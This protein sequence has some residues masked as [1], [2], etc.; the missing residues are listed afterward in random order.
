MFAARLKQLRRERKISQVELA[1]LLN[2]TQQ[3]VGKWETGRSSPDQKTLKLLADFFNTTTDYLLDY[4]IKLPAVQQYISAIEHPIPVIGSVKAGYGALAL[5]D[6][7]GVEYARVKNPEN[8]FYLTVKGNS[9]EPRIQ[10]GD[11]ALV[12][13]QN[14]LNDGDL[15]VVI[16]GDDAEGTLKKFI[17]KDNAV[18][19]QP[20]NPNYESIVLVGEELDHLYIAGKVI[21]TKTKW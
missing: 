8:Y 14:T 2:I 12:H 11:L 15:G 10:N 20:F 6:D 3:A 13:K 16:F 17:C 4:D 9:M 21:E 7:L 1:K 5:E 18:V 19:L